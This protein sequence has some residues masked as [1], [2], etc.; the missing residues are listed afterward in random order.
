MNFHNVKHESKLQN[1]KVTYLGA[2]S[3]KTRSIGFEI[4]YILLSPGTGVDRVSQLEEGSRSL[5]PGR[6][7]A[8][9]T[10]TRQGDATVWRDGH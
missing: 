10:A 1:F 6:G 3:L 2:A 8:E 9:A 7:T 4:L 5:R